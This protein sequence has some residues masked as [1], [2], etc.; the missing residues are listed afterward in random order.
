VFFPLVFTPH[1]VNYFDPAIACVLLI[2]AI[3]PIVYLWGAQT[4]AHYR[5]RTN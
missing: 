2:L 5:Y 1:A 4:L 3:F